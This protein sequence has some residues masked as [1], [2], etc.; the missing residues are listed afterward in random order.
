MPVAPTAGYNSQL[1]EEF[2]R[3]LNR[4]TIGLLKDVPVGNT[5]RTANDS[6]LQVQNVVPIGLAVSY[7]EFLSMGLVDAGALSGRRSRP[8]NDD[9][10]DDDA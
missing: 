8:G 4:R 5:R 10:D 3:Y 7:L 6:W 9:D 1:S 2:L